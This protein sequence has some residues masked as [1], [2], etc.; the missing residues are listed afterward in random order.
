MIEKLGK[1][2]PMCRKEVRHL[3]EGTKCI[4]TNGCN[5]IIAKIID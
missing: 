3:E 2:T 1:G 5:L 4:V